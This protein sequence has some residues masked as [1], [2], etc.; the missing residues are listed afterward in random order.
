MIIRMYEYDSFGTHVCLHLRTHITIRV[1]GSMF[2]SKSAKIYRLTRL[3][4]LFTVCTRSLYEYISDKEHIFTL[5][6]A[7]CFPFFVYF[8]FSIR[9][10][11]YNILIAYMCLRLFERNL[12]SNLIS[13]ELCS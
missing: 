2:F 8:E 1:I 4:A 5:A 13:E 9:D 3:T 6:F 11:H 12:R 7:Q 10:L